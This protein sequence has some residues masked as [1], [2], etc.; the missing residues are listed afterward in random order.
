LRTTSCAIVLS[1]IA[2]WL[3]R[4]KLCLICEIR[5]FKARACKCARDAGRA[6]QRLVDG[7]DGDLAHPGRLEEL[8]VGTEWVKL[9]QSEKSPCW[10]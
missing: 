5:E 6:H 8:A 7:S 4:A 10:Q 2:L 9:S 3:T 1:L